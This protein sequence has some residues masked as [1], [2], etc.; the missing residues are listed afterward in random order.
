MKRT[1][2][3]LVA[4]TLGAS[5]AALAQTAPEVPAD[6]PAVDAPVSAGHLARRRDASADRG[7]ISSRAETVFEGE[8]TVNSYELF[9]LGVT[10][11]ITDDIQVSG[12]TF[13]PITTDIPLLGLFQGKF[14]LHRGE[15]VTV[16]ARANLN[17]I[18]P[19]EVDDFVGT[20]GG[21]LMVDY[22]LDD[23]GRFALH[24]GFGANAVFGSLGD[25]A[26]ELANGAAISL[27]LGASAA[28]GNSVKLI[29]DALIPA[30]STD[31]GFEV[32]TFGL[33][34]YGVRFFGESLA[35]DLGFLRPVGDID[36]DGFVLG[37]PYVAFSARF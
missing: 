1:L 32:A 24:G 6:D 36:L 28:L 19:Q 17:V 11:G 23:S 18:A 26:I 30:A 4:A 33:V 5:P 9:F 3:L 35:A 14:V 31:Q 29:F 20:F 15:R 21:G 27:E 10:Y 2:A 16:S 13:L 25:S 7:F 12:T 37:I 22:Y 8:A 34:T